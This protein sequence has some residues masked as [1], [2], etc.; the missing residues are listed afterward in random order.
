MRY[1][2]TTVGGPVPVDMIEQTVGKGPGYKLTVP[3]YASMA[4][5]ER[6]GR[7]W[8]VTISTPGR[9][10]IKRGRL[11]SRLTAEVVQVYGGRMLVRYIEENAIPLRTGQIPASEPTLPVD[12]DAP[13]RTGSAPT[14]RRGKYGHLR[15]NH[16][17]FLGA[18]LDIAVDV[19]W[20]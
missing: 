12:R 2:I 17:G 5:F 13:H 16:E 3:G 7:W 18:I 6:D 14:Y 4:L 1:E 19:F 9:M 20:G 10:Y 8:N 11:D 15:R